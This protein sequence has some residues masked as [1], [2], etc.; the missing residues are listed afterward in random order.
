[1]IIKLQL[2]SKIKMN[3]SSSTTNLNPKNKLSLSE[4][5]FKKID[6]T[7]KSSLYN[8]KNIKFAEIYKQIFSKNTGDAIKILKQQKEALKSCEYDKKS[9]N[10]K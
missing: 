4:T 10:Q 8:F 9:T 3:F 1:M 7:A 5:K 6:L 2:I